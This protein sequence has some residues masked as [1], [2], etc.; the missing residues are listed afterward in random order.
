MRGVQVHGRLVAAAAALDA[1]EAAARHAAHLF[2]FNLVAAMTAAYGV[3][4]IAGPLMASAL[5]SHG[6]SFNGAM[7]I[8]SAALL[9]AA[10]ICEI[11]STGQTG[12]T[13]QT[14]S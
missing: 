9:I 1:P 10:G 7:E 11:R 13:H 14:H 2:R 4:Q 12:Q 8:A 5:M 3:G 6:G